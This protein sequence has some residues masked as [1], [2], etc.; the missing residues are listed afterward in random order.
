MGDRCTGH[1]CHHFTLDYHPAKL[2]ARAQQLAQTRIT[3]D[4][5]YPGPPSPP[6]EL[7]VVASMAIY[8]GTGTPDPE[9][10]DLRQFANP[11]DREQIAHF[12]TCRRLDKETGNCSDYDN[13]PKMCSAY[14]HYGREVAQCNYN[15]CTWDAVHF[16]TCGHLAKGH[17]LTRGS[18]PYGRGSRLP[19]GVLSIGRDLRD[20]GKDELCKEAT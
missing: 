12:Y 1:C 16:A 3:N 5:A 6:S 2:A 19:A 14:P 10:F 15:A 8:L 4:L 13:R 18:S 11:E 7:E 17:R 20:L 9:V